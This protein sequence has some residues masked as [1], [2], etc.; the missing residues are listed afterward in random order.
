MATIDFKRSIRLIKMPNKGPKFKNVEPAFTCIRWIFHD[1]IRKTSFHT[2]FRCSNN[3]TTIPAFLNLD[4]YLS[5]K[6]INQAK[7]ARLA[8]LPESSYGHSYARS[9]ILCLN[10]GFPNLIL[11][12]RYEASVNFYNRF[13]F[14]RFNGGPAWEHFSRA[15]ALSSW[16]TLVW[17]FVRKSVPWTVPNQSV[18]TVPNVLQAKWRVHMSAWI[19][20]RCKWR[21]QCGADGKMIL[22]VFWILFG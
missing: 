21:L 19:L 22:I 3:E 8:N 20:S 11:W 17:Q 9:Y 4:Y 13:H 7:H 18:P 6:F 16:R 14:G 12:G 15:H 2:I 5:Q 1:F 10:W